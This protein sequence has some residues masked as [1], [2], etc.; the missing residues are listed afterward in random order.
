MVLLSQMLNCNELFELNES[1][2]W[3]FYTCVQLVTSHGRDYKTGYQASV[4]FCLKKKCIIKILKKCKI[5]AALVHLSLPKPL[6][7]V[8]FN[9]EDLNKVAKSSMVSLYYCTMKHTS[10]LD[11]VVWMN[12][13]NFLECLPC[14]NN[15]GLPWWTMPGEGG[16]ILALWYGST[17]PIFSSAFLVWMNLPNFLECLP[18]ENNITLPWWTMPCDGAT[19]LAILHEGE[20][21]D[22]S[23]LLAGLL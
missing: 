10:H 21:Y 5:C 14:E 2:T 13:P 9:A 6:W 11:P 22:T 7:A 16:T 23:N 8:I 12:L 20:H 4:K 19:I 18:C 1:F 3:N 17:Y 15:I